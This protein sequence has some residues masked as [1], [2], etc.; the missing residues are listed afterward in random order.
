MISLRFGCDIFVLYFFVLFIFLAGSAYVYSLQHY[1]INELV[2]IISPAW[3]YYPGIPDV[4][5]P[6][7]AVHHVILYMQCTC[8]NR[9]W[10]ICIYSLKC[11]Y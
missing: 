3:C 6:L 5:R 2:K 11:S 7:I 4:T 10:I 1:V 9:T 8:D